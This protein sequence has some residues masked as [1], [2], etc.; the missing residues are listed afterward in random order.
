M[1]VSNRDEWLCG[2]PA[3]D[4]MLDDPIVRLVMRRDGITERDVRAAI[5]PM[6]AV[7]RA[8]EPRLVA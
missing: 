2:E 6:I 5:A 7:L 1:R 8:A 4:D 3:I